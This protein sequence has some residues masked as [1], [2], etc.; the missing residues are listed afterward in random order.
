[1]IK[2]KRGHIVA[3]SSLGGK[4]TFPMSCAY[5]ATKFG[6]RGFMSA[7]FDE[8]CLD[9]SDEFVKTTCVFPSF[10]STRKELSDLLDQT[11]EL[12]PRMTPQYVA[13]AVVQGIQANARDVTVPSTGS[14][15]QLIK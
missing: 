3:I 12:A 11:K 6:V 2:Q 7:L 1:M 14:Y 9:N 15:F 8:L 10:I 4:V 5:C 13:N